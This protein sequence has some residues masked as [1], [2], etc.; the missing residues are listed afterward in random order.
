MTNLIATVLSRRIALAAR[1]G[2][3]E[4]IALARDL[5][6]QHVDGLFNR[7]AVIDVAGSK[8][9]Q[10]PKRFGVDIGKMRFNVH[11]GNAVLRSFLDRDGEDVSAL[12]RVE[13]RFRIHDVEVGVAVLQIKPAN[14][15][16]I[17]GYPVRIIDIARLDE[18]QEVHLGRLIKPTRRLVE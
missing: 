15:F 2:L 18:G 13:V 12:R 3:R 16:E 17:G 7:V 5:A 8:L 4:G 11:G 10:R 1:T 6:R 14:Q 9:H